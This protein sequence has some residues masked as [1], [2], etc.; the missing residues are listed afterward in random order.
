MI[1]AF[2]KAEGSQNDFVIVDNRN[3]SIDEET[4]RSIS[5]AVCHR[6]KAVGADG[7]IFIEPSEVSDFTMR[8]YNP[9]GSEGSMCG[10][11]GRCAALYAFDTGIAADKMTFDVLGKKY[12]GEVYPAAV[13]LYFPEP[14]DIRLNDRLLIDGL[15][16]G[17]DF[18]HTGAPHSIVF[19]DDLP[20]PLKREFLQFPVESVG[21]TIR[22]Q[23][24]YNPAGANVNFIQLDEEQTVHIRTFEK[25][26]EAETEAC[27]TGSIASA[28]AAVLRRGLHPPI[29]LR[30]RA[31]EELT[32]GFTLHGDIP[33][34]AEDASAVIPGSVF[35]NGLYLEGR[36]NLAFS[37]ML[38]FDAET[39]TLRAVY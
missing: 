27:G 29:R 21:A 25:G 10:N 24:L 5:I 19:I 31:G 18:V 15:E 9:D 14:G 33:T 20:A 12:N 7:V 30:T 22:H 26:V 2:T 13:R 37:G 16:I 3:R 11:G 32:V 6:R 4:Q 39:N 17:C 35:A 23:K 1:I 8:F 34:L 28:I 38:D 36:A